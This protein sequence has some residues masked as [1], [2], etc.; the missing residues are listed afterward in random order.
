[1]REAMK[2]RVRERMSREASLDD[3]RLDDGEQAAFG[4]AGR[5]GIADPPILTK[6]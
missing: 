4:E 5:P 2:R 1:M 3:P 6:S